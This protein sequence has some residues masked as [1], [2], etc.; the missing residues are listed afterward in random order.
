[1]SP[2]INNISGIAY[3]LWLWNAEQ[4]YMR[5]SFTFISVQVPCWI[6][7]VFHIHLPFTPIW[8]LTNLYLIYIRSW[9]NGMAKPGSQCLVHSPVWELQDS[10]PAHFPQ[11]NLQVLPYV[12]NGHP[13][14]IINHEVYHDRLKMLIRQS[15][16]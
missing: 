11:L 13:L 3:I 14:N 15:L 4:Q 12:P 2:H 10:S 6:Y 16:K 7:I 8:F 1:M 5:H 9:H